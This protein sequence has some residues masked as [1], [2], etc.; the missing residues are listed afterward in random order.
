LSFERWNSP[1]NCTARGVSSG[2]ITTTDLS[3]GMRH[4][5]PMNKSSFRPLRMW[6]LIMICSLA[7]MVLLP[8]ASAQSFIPSFPHA[9]R[10]LIRRGDFYDYSGIP[11]VPDSAR[12]SYGTGLPTISPD[13]GPSE[14][15]TTDDLRPYW[16]SGSERWGYGRRRFWWSWNCRRPDWG[17]LGGY[18]HPTSFTNPNPLA[19]MYGY[20]GLP[21]GMDIPSCTPAEVGSSVPY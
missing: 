14:I 19:Y 13:S 10:R 6:T 11:G 1:L 5:E 12:G 9:V 18:Y 2:F 17:G 3:R 20:R 15:V 4:A 7:V 21:P 16:R 8:Y